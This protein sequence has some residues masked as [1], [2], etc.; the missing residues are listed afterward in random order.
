[1]KPLSANA[2][3]VLCLAGLAVLQFGW[4]VYPALGTTVNVLNVAF[5]LACLT[6]YVTTKG[7][8]RM[9]DLLKLITVPLKLIRTAWRRYYK[10]AGDYC[11]KHGNNDPNDDSGQ[12]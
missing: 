2:V 11:E 7:A 4:L 8:R 9:T 3:C 12:W 1:M 10:W 6:A 5:V